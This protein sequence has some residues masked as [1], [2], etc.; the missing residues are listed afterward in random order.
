MQGLNEE[1]AARDRALR[2]AAQERSHQEETLA[3]VRRL[4]HMPQ[5]ASWRLGRSLLA[6]KHCCIFRNPGPNCL[7]MLR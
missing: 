4:C 7:T 6:S 2:R 3:Q 1:L 5:P